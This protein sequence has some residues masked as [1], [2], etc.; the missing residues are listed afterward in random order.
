MFAV[1]DTL[2]TSSLETLTIPAFT[3]GVAAVAGNIGWLLKK[4]VGRRSASGA[5]VGRNRN[6]GLGLFTPKIVAKEDG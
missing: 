2:I 3:T 1:P 5:L 6:A 4:T